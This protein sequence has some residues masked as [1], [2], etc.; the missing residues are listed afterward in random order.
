MCGWAG[1]VQA[2]GADFQGMVGKLREPELPPGCEPQGAS[3]EFWKSAGMGARGRAGGT[4]ACMCN[5][6]HCGEF[7]F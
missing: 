6:D 2:G 4:K 1:W 5:D 3:G 7:G